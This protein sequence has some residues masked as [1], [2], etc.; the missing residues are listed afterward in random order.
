MVG[1]IRKGVS[2]SVPRLCRSYLSNCSL[3]SVSNGCVPMIPLSSPG[4]LYDFCLGAI[5]GELAFCI[6]E[7][8][9]P[10][11]TVKFLPLPNFRTSAT[12]RFIP[13]SSSTAMSILSSYSAQASTSHEKKSDAPTRISSLGSPSSSVGIFTLPTSRSV[14]S[15]TALF[16]IVSKLL[17]FRALSLSSLHSP[18]LTDLSIL[19]VPN[20]SN[21]LTRATITV[22]LTTRAHCVN[23]SSSIELQSQL[24]IVQSVTPGSSSS[25]KALISPVCA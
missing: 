8:H 14:F 7:Q 6:P 5:V 16:L 12:N 21:T 9:R 11:T 23:V 20:A 4:N 15:L 17:F 13:Y 10:V 3:V 2:L 25:S 19:Q 18:L 22:S 1:Y 24:C